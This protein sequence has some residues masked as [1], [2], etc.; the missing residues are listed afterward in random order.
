MKNSSGIN[1]LDIQ[2]VLMMQM[3]KLRLQEDLKNNNLS[4]ERKLI[5]ARVNKIIK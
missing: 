3:S 1:G 2:R 5:L 4:H